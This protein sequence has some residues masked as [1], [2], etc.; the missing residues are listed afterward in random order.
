M[1]LHYAVNTHCLGVVE[2]ILQYGPELNSKIANGLTPLHQALF[3][4]G[5]DKRIIDRLLDAG[6]SL[7]KKS[8]AGDSA[9]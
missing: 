3:A 2:R 9:L 7:S 6:C 1:A 5:I 4:K 8:D